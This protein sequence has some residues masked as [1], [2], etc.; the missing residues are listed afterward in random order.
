MCQWSGSALVQVMAG[1]L[2]SLVC[3]VP[4]HYLNQ[5]WL[6]VIWTPG[7]KFQSNS[8]RN[9]IIF[10]SENAFEIVVCH[11]GDH[12]VQGRWVKVAVPYVFSN[13]VI[14]V[15]AHV[16][17]PLGT[18]PS[19]GLNMKMLSNQIT[20]WG[21]ETHI[22]VGKFTIIG[23]DNGLSPGRRQAIIWTNGGILLIG[24]LGTNFNGI[25]IEIHTFSVMKMHLKMSSAKWRPF[26]LSLNVL[27]DFHNKDKTVLSFSWNLKPKKTS[28]LLKQGSAS[29]AL[30]SKA[31]IFL[32][33]LFSYSRF[34]WTFPRSEPITKMSISIS[35]L[36][37][38]LPAVH[39]LPIA[40]CR[41]TPESPYVGLI[42]STP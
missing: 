29:T 12:F 22:C 38:S 2:F 31:D 10:I 34:L 25:L 16:L 13:L 17:G 14:T 39:C 6:I 18:R 4:S 1:R 32:Q 21:R 35:P 40:V 5:C 8:N 27:R 42:T 11:K 30:T 33:D 36:K 7:N 41:H 9:F 15:P 19:G 20:H 28:L 23:S 37:G 3:S 24:P 26:C